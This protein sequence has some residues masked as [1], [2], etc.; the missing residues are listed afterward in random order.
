MPEWM[1]S[2]KDINSGTVKSYDT[3]QGVWINAEAEPAVATGTQLVPQTPGSLTT[4]YAGY[5]QPPAGTLSLTA[6]A[7][8]NSLIGTLSQG[9]NG[10]LPAQEGTPLLALP[11][12]DQPAGLLTYVERPYFGITPSLGVNGQKLDPGLYQAMGSLQDLE[13]YA[14]SP[15]AY[16][17]PGRNRAGD[18]LGNKR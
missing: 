11:A 3:R 8:V 18:V 13:A 7:G 1:V 9:A 10:G 6:R 12:S 14:N 15:L 16:S 17:L 4:A 5:G 2:L